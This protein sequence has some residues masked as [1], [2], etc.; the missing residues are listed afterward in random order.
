MDCHTG[1]T[2]HLIVFLVYWDNNEEREDLV[3]A[4][5]Y[6]EESTYLY[7]APHLIQAVFNKVISV[8]SDW[9]Q[10]T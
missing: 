8:L 4:T 10:G 6:T 7:S 3:K 1:N 2:F 5:R 9:V